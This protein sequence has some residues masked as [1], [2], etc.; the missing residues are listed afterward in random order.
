M[1]L[2][3]PP[4]RERPDDILPLARTF[5]REAARRFGLDPPTFSAA[6][7]THLTSR[8]WPGNVRELKH[9]V[10]RLVALATGP[11]IGAADL[12]ELQQQP[13]DGDGKASLKAQVDA[14]EKDLLR[15]TMDEYGQNQSQAAR[16]LLVSRG[17]L[18]SKL[19]K[20]GLG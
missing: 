18:I 14:F 19:K 12:D 10:E 9:A 13:A 6:A 16:E 5:A 15:R 8:A 20:H 2:R 3:V 4:L 17:T 11:L 1:T 7:L